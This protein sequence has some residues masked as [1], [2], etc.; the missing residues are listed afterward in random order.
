MSACALV[1]TL[2]SIV[3]GWWRRCCRCDWCLLLVESEEGV[4]G[5]NL[6]KTHV[7]SIT[8]LQESIRVISKVIGDVCEYDLVTLPNG[9]SSLAPSLK[10][11]A[12]MTL[13]TCSSGHVPRRILCGLPRPFG[14]MSVRMS[15]NEQKK[16]C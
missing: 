2:N 4:D 8:I 7:Q 11:T 1:G 15:R 16:V 13:R 5:W 9:N 14:L 3:G 6:V 12:R 10:T